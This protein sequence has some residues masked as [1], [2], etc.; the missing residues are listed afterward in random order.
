MVQARRGIVGG[1]GWTGGAG[2][3]SSAGGRQRVEGA[4]VGGVFMLG[5]QLRTMVPACCDAERACL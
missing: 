1:A 4:E 3:G 5:A 2:A